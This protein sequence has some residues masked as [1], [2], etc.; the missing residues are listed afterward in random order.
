M[1]CSKVLR[2][3]PEHLVHTQSPREGA[4]Q[5]QGLG[6]TVFI[7]RPGS[8]SA[9]VQLREEQQAVCQQPKE[10]DKVHHVGLL[11]QLC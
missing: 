9:A 5:T 8:E 10:E 11:H 1:T 3:P 6:P 7:A 4:G 2:C